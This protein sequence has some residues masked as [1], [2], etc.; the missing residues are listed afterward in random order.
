MERDKIQELFCEKISM[1]LSRYKQKMLRQEPE[2]IFQRAYQID[3]I[4]NIY[5]LLLELSRKT[6]EETLRVMLVFPNLLAFFYRKWMKQ[7]D[8]AAEELKEGLEKSIAELKEAY[9]KFAVKEN[10][11]A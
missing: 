8:S 5:E 9:G 4:I 1:E 6:E 10:D 11:A 2:F 3:S 7:E